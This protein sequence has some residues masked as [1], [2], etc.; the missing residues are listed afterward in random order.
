MWPYIT[1]TTCPSNWLRLSSDQSS[2][3][4][5]EMKAGCGRSLG[6]SSSDQSGAD[7]EGIGEMHFGE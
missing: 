5:G 6:D 1:V 2:W 7:I 3:E 4:G